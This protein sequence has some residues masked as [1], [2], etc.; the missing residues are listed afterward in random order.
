MADTLAAPHLD[1]ASWLAERRRSHVFEVERISLPDLAGWSFDAST[2]NLVHDSGRF[3][4]V[5]G[6]HVSSDYGPVPEWWQPIIRQPEFGILGIL[7][8]RV[9][10]VIHCLLQAKPEPGN[11]NVL[12]LSPTVQ[13]TRSNYTRVHRGDGTRYLDYFVPPYRGRVLIDVLQSEQ[14]VWFY[15]KRNR[16]MIVEVHEDVEAQEDFLWLP[17]EEIWHLLKVDNLVNMDARSVL[18]CLPLALP[19]WL[20]ENEG[21]CDDVR[22]TVRDSF[23]GAGPPRLSTERLLNWFTEVKAGYRTSVRRVPLAKVKN[24]HR[25]EY[26]ISHEDGKFFSVL[27]VSVRASGREV[28]HWTQPLIAP[29]GEGVAAFV[30]KRIDGVLHVLAQARVEPGFVDVMEL[31]PTVL[32][33]PDNYHDLP[34]SDWP[35]FLAYVLAAGPERIRYSALLSEEGGRFYCAQT[36]YLLVEAGADEEIDVRPNYQ[37]MTLRQLTDL[38]RHSHYLNVQA[39]SLLACVSSV[40]V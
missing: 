33:N 14:G 23:A 27:A 4:A 31:A 25:T 40:L 28:S 10:G 34:R 15:R 11:V 26:E 7:V 37:W 38:L 36:R 18:S 32:C 9:R 24:W 19:D 8:K 1:L 29:R 39:R 22:R 6:V 35:P 30:A 2:G 12:Q 16:N 20:G 3:F 21:A 5:E 13:A 17:L